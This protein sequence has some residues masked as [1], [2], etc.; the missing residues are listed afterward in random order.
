M[1]GPITA[2]RVRE[3]GAKPETWGGWAWRF[4]PSHLDRIAQA[5]A[6]LER[7]EALPTNYVLHH[8]SPVYGDDD[9]QTTEWQVIE[10]YGGINDRETRVI[11]RG[12]TAVAALAAVKEVSGE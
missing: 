4:D 9:D 10:E 3:L 11:A 6:L 5:L 12:D 8:V 1:S 2:A 7:V